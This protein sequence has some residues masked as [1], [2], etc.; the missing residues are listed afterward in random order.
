LFPDLE[1]IRGDRQTNNE[2]GISALSASRRWDAAID[3][4]P[5]EPAVVMPTARL[6]AD[7]TDF[8]SFV[9]SIGAYAD[10]SHPGTEE[11]APLRMNEPGYGGDK[12]D[13]KRSLDHFSER[14]SGS[15]AHAPLLALVMTAFRFTTG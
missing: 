11:S 7:R 9:S 3:V 5:S 4:W 2:G 10:T 1:K 13:L 8:Y 6:L 12:R 15:F 14:S